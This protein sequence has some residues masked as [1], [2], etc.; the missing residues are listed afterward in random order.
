MADDQEQFE[1]EDLRGELADDVLISNLR[2]D[3]Q[4]WEEHFTAQAQTQWDEAIKLW[5]ARHLQSPRAGRSK[6]FIQKP[7]SGVRRINADLLD[8]FFSSP[9]YVTVK[10]GRD[11]RSDDVMAARVRQIYLNHVYS[12]NPINWFKICFSA[13]D[14]GCVLNVIAAEVSWIKE[15]DR[16]EFTQNTPILNPVTGEPLIDPDAGGALMDSVKKTMEILIRDEPQVRLIPPDRIGFD[17]RVSW[18][19][20]YAGQFIIHKD[21]MLYQELLKIAKTDSKIDKEA[22]LKA[23]SYHRL[24]TNIVAATRGESGYTFDDPA[25]KEI[26]VWK[27]YYK[28]MGK[29][30]AAWLNGSLS[31]LRKPESISDK[32]GLPPIILGFL[33]PESHK[34]YS[35]SKVHQN[36]DN[37][38]Q[39]NGIRNQ[40]MDNV[41]RIMNQHAIVSRDKN[42]DLASLVNRRPL[43]YTLCDGDPRDAVFYEQ[44]PDL[45]ASSYN[46][47]TIVDRDIQELFGVNDL[48]QGVDSS[49]SNELATQSVIR[50]ENMN[51]KSAVNVR[52]IAESFIVPVSRRV[53]QLADEHVSLETLLEIVGAD[54]PMTAYITAA[55]GQADDEAPTMAAIRG[56]YSVKVYAGLGFFSKDAS[57]KNYDIAFQRILSAY[58]PDATVPML[59]EYLMLLGVKNAS[60]VVARAE[61]TLELTRIITALAQRNKQA[62]PGRAKERVRATGAREPGTGI[63]ELLNAGGGG[64]NASI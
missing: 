46:E 51:K 36:R 57:L 43:G 64:G 38:V 1:L 8:A 14:D 35:P 20:I 62:G 13:F 22:L 50:Q 34:V 26:D 19:D 17:P 39:L 11:K 24:N 30:W 52:M 7:R 58:G 31:V 5:Q 49:R 12:S 6:L 9:D 15:I 59:E 3:N 53:L 56:Q 60:E 2:K 28:V 32:H 21:P 61:Q 48:S 44:I 54:E 33:D 4:A 10:P 40:R 41:A 18:E 25:R 29:W 55:Y 63:R 23:V 27:Y 42:V 47:E 37:F 45:K 16:I